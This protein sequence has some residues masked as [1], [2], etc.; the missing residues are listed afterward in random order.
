MSQLCVIG[1][2]YRVTAQFLP[3]IVVK[4]EVGVA[5][6]ISAVVHVVFCNRKTHLPWSRLLY[7]LSWVAVLRKASRCHIWSEERKREGQLMSDWS[8]TRDNFTHDWARCWR[9]YA[10]G[11]RFADVTAGTV[12]ICWRH[13]QWHNAQ[14]G[15]DIFWHHVEWK[16]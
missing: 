13:G 3:D 7:V 11:Q 4:S 14:I 5:L 16:G 15:L 1:L 2:N 6:T 12:D 10:I 9:R 8:W